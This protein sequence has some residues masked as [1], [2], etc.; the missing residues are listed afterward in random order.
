[1][2]KAFTDYRL[3][4]QKAYVASR[5]IS[6]PVVGRGFSPVWPILHDY[7]G[8]S[9]LPVYE[10]SYDTQWLGTC[11]HRLFKIPIDTEK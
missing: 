7:V 4:N 2:S 11:R 8:D 1:M 3:K 10:R 9:N 5:N 6:R